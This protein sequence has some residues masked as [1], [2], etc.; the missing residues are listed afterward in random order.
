[1]NA[2]S[3]LVW[4]Q[5]L[6]GLAAVVGAGHSVYRG[7]VRQ[8]VRA[9]KIVP[10]IEEKVEHLDDRLQKHTDATLALVEAHDRENVDVDAVRMREELQPEPD[11][12]RFVNNERRPRD[13]E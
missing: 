13:S 6:V 4:V 9:V 7:T 11:E 3:V 1:M 2:E 5:I 12:G 8:A 10:E